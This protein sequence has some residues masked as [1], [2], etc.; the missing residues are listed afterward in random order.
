M[1]DSP[2]SLRKI[3]KI[4][5][6][7]KSVSLKQIKTLE[8]YSGKFSVKDAVY[9]IALSWN[10]VKNTTLQKCWRNLRPAANPA[11]DLTLQT[12]EE[13]NHQDALTKVLDVVRSADN[14]LKNLPED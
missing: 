9:A 12:D 2:T 13:E 6:F 4:L 14:P 11:S 3:E 10:Q 8:S 5:V 1:P 7:S